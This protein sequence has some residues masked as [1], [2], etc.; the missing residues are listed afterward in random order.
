MADGLTPAGL[1]R[2][3]WDSPAFVGRELLLMKKDLPE[4][5]Q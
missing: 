5:R 1:E 4:K 3:P 2:R